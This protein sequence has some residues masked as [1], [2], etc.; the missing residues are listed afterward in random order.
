MRVALTPEYL[1]TLIRTGQLPAGI[2]HRPIPGG[3]YK[4]DVQALDAWVKNGCFTETP[5]DGAG[6][7]AASPSYA[8]DADDLDAYVRHFEQERDNGNVEPW[9][10]PMPIDEWADSEPRPTR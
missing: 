2:V 1:G 7:A 4:I 5:G 8:D 6:G 10:E 3:H 9:A